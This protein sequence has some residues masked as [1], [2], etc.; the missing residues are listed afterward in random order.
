ME[1]IMSKVNKPLVIVGSAVLAVAMTTLVSTAEAGKHHGGGFRFH[2][3]HVYIAPVYTETYRVVRKPVVQE[4]VAVI[5]YA[6]GMGRVYDLASKV[7]HDGQNHC[8]SGKLAWTFKNGSWF[9][10][11]YSWSEADGTWR[12]SSPEAP[13]S[14]ACETV[15]AFAGKFT[16]T[17]GLA[18]GQKEF[19]RNSEKGESGEPRMAPKIVAPPVKTAEKAPSEEPTQLALPADGNATRAGQ[20]KKYF[21]SVGEMLPVPCTSD[22]SSL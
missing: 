20:C 1:N 15:P 7:W 12:T 18:N 16:P 8:W 21:P 6:D 5:R 10:G 4:K 17:V 2:H 3:R 11:S 19:A 13:R 14:V 22:H 9:Y